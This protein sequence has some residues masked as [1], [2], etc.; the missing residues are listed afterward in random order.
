MSA[1]APAQALQV[2]ELTDEGRARVQAV[3]TRAAEDIE[4]RERL[5]SDAD[6]A[7][8]STDLTP[9]EK[10]VLSVMRRVALEE[11][12]VDVRRFRSFLRDNGNRIM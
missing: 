6:G 3:L 4:F 7:L 5:L 9:E 10:S 1:V 2:P 12:G 11:W 8:A